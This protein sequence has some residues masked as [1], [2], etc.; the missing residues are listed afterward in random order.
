MPIAT[1][2]IRPS[3]A[4]APAAVV[5]VAFWKAASRK[6][7]VSRPSRRTARKAIPT[8]AIVEPAASA[9]AASPSSVAL[10]PRA[11]RRIQTIM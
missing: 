2:A 10:I 7:E 1:A 9:E 11:L 8:S 3:T 6:T 4:P 5:S